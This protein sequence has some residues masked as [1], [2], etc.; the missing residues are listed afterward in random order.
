MSKKEDNPASLETFR[1]A[2]T[3][4]EKEVARLKEENAKLK[5]HPVVLGLGREIHSIE[6]RD[7]FAKDLIVE[8]LRQMHFDIAARAHLMTNKDVRDAWHKSMTSMC[9][10]AYEIA[11]AML[12]ARKCQ[13]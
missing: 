2:L 4:A 7:L 9:G 10:E 6:L 8:V 3:D 1:L 13:P 11:D 12:E 5:A